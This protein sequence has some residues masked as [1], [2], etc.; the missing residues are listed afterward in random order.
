[1]KVLV[2]GAL[3]TIGH[4][5]TRE[6]QRR[7]N[8]VWSCDLQHYHIEKYYRCDVGNYRQLSRIFDE[9]KFDYVY[10]L[11]AEFGRWNGEDYYDILWKT[12]V[13]GTKNIIRLQE[14]HNYKLIFTSSSEI[15][16]DFKGIMKEDIMDKYEIKQLNDYAIT[17]WAN[18]LQ[19]INSQKMHGTESVRIR[20][21]NTYG[22]GEYYSPY[23]SVICRFI[24]HALYNMP[25]KVFLNH[26][27]SSSYVTDTVST[28]CNI[29]DSFIPGEV[30]NIGGSQ[31]HDIK[32][33]SDLILSH[34]G[35]D[36]KQVEYINSEPF[37]TMD[38]KPDISKAKRD[39]GHNPK[40]SL[41]EGIPRTIEWMK[42]VYR[43]IKDE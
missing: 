6:L 15:Y 1:M 18:E 35:K 27:R 41:K 7:G 23:R 39:L 34:L 11:A 42:E 2:T 26:H 20:L 43:P 38:K 28:L 22:P 9:H 40:V 24:Y 32:Y 30:Y 16:G 33:V 31:F 21:F 8:N 4:V 25:Y 14:K 3:G 5:L 17:K 13:I 36:D 29:V 10:H 19:I 37:T 12:N